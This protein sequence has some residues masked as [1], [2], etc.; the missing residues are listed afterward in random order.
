MC[1]AVYAYPPSSLSK[2]SLN[3]TADSSGIVSYDVSTVWK[4]IV[5]E[6]QIIQIVKFIFCALRQLYSHLVWY[7]MQAF[8]IKDQNKCIYH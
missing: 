4:A 5:S 2:T 3:K 7:E 6:M 8:D 1:I